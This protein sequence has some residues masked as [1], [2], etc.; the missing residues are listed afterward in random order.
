MAEPV[1]ALRGVT[2]RFDAVTALDDVSIDFHVG[3]VH[4]LLG[5]NGSGKSTTVRILTGALTPD[6]GTVAIDGQDVAFATPRAAIDAGIAAA[7]QESALVPHLTVAQNV[8]LGHE[9]TRLG[10][11]AG[12]ARAEARRWLD[13]VGLEVRP[14]ARVSRLS[15]A[16]QQL[17]AIAK[18][19]SLQ[20]RVLILDE[21]TAALNGTEV[22]HLIGLVRTLRD[23]GLAIVYITHR[24]AEVAQIADT[25]TVLKDGRLVTTRPAAGLTEDEIVPLMVGREVT[26]LYPER[27]AP[28][29]DVVLSA[30]GLR[31]SDGRVQV[32]AFEL[33]A[34]E[35]VGIAGLEGSGRSVLARM[36]AGVEPG[37]SGE[38]VLRGEAL[39]RPTPGRALRRG[40]GYV[41]PDRR[42]Q[43]IVPTFSVGRSITL[44][45]LWSFSHVSVIRPRAERERARRFIDRFAIKAAGASAPIRTLSGGNQQK[46]VLSR[47]LCAGTRVLVCDEPTA[48]VDI[49]ARGEIYHALSGLAADGHG[50]V[51][52][53][54]DMLELLGLCHRIVVM[55]EGRPALEIPAD[56]A[57][58]EVLMRAQLPEV[59]AAAA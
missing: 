12:G 17:V 59:G 23:R 51:V 16:E 32:D 45:S 55:R 13:E 34:G 48:G 11:L 3:T 20:A 35:I 9:R 14:E 1:A 7:Y 56:G 33:H 31:T 46:V 15:V 26:Q 58:E 42:R 52:S 8:V 22:D 21:P 25:V 40:L 19:L 10:V 54:S 57:S 44:A 41:P 37:A 47:V 18:A 4:A 24:L 30:S 2:R 43:A 38:L 6:E 53:S 5:E 49:G 39:A 36:L 50:V 29:D 27:P 28:A